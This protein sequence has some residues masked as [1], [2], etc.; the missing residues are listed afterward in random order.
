MTDMHKPRF[1]D[2]VNEAFPILK[3]GVG[4]LIAAIVAWWSLVGKVA[5]LE[6]HDVEQDARATR[7]EQALQQQRTDTAQQLRDISGDVKDIRSYLMNNAAGA[8]PDTRRWSK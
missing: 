2:R 1:M 6:Q 3:W 8:R 7:L 5:A 4:L